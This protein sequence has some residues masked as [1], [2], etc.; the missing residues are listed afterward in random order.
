LRARASSQDGE[1]PVRC[2]VLLA[3]TATAEAIVLDDPL[4]FWGGFDPRT[5][6]IIDRRHP[7]AGA[8]LTG[9][10]VVM[11]SGRGSSSSG[12]VLAEAIRAGTAPAAILL[13]EV[14]EILLVGALAAAELYG[15]EM[16]LCV[17]PAGALSSIASG[18]RL[19]LHSD[20]TLTHTPAAA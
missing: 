10:I 19:T 2:R 11:P 3:G 12:S 15:V 18:D 14:D 8:P 1:T 4:S 20:G 6:A 9:R 16:P 5:G 7:Q 13:A 17:L